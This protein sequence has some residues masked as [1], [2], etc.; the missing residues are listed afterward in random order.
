MVVDD[1]AAFSPGSLTVDISGDE[2]RGFSWAR[3]T[4]LKQ[5][6]FDVATNIT[7]YAADRSPSYL[8]NSATW[9]I[10][11]APASLPAVGGCWPS[12]RQRALA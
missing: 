8:W 10:S 6:T 4:S 7:D 12:A 3:P 5:P 9:G 2:A 11:E 1:L